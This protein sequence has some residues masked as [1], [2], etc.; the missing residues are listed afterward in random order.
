[1]RIVRATKKLTIDLLKDESG[2][3]LL[4]YSILVGLIT[5]GV[6]ATISTVGTWVGEQWT[7]LETNLGIG[8]AG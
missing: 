6:V 2:A 7:D 3:S 5:A 1:M 4:E 8:G